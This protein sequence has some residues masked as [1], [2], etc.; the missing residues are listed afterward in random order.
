[1]CYV[2]TPSHQDKQYFV[3]FIDDYSQKLWASKSTSKSSRPEL[4]ESRVENS[5]LS[6]LTMVANIEDSSRNTTRLKA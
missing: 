2:D 5:R 6:E 1:M 3:T 4:R